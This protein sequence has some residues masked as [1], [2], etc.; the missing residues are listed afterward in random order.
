[1]KKFSVIFLVFISTNLFAQTDTALLKQNVKLSMDSVNTFFKER[2]WEGFT[3]FMHPSLVSLIGTKEDFISFI[4]EQMK[5]LEIAEVQRMEAGEVIQIVKE[6]EEWQALVMAHSQMKIDSMIIS[7][8]S[9]NIAFSA[10]EGNTWKFIRVSNGSEQGIKKSFPQISQQLKIPLNKMQ[11]MEL[12]SMLA[13]YT[14]EYVSEPAPVVKKKVTA[15]KKKP[16]SKTKKRT[17]A[18]KRKS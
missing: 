1:M 10:D 17:V 11:F 13:D 16:V 14:M 6:N 3:N 18:V 9:S 12:D 2:N 5:T 8:I 7:S 15:A 4:A